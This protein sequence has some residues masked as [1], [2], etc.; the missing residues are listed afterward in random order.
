[1]CPNRLFKLR[2]YLCDNAESES[3]PTLFR[4]VSD[5]GLGYTQIRQVLTRSGS[6]ANENPTGPYPSSELANNRNKVRQQQL[7]AETAKLLESG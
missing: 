4:E 2:H 3:I 5:V 6:D 1:M 7:R